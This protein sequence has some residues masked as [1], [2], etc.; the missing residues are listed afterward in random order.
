METSVVDE[1]TEVTL[2]GPKEEPNSEHPTESTTFVVE[3]AGDGSNRERDKTMSPISFEKT[4][5]RQVQAALRRLHQNL[6]HPS[7]E[8]LVRHLRLAG[9]GA[10]VVKAAKGMSCQVCARH[11]RAGS[12]RPSSE[13]VWL[14]FN[15]VVGVDVFTIHTPDD[16]KYDLLSVIDYGTSYHV[17][18]LLP[19]HNAEEIE[20]TFNSLWSNTFGPPGTI[21]LDQ[22]PG[23]QT[24][25][26]RYSSWYG[27]KIRSSAGQGH[28]QQGRVER[29]GRHWKEILNRVMDDLSVLQKDELELAVIATNSAKNELTKIHGFSPAQMVFGRNPKTL[30]ELP[31]IGREDEVTITSPDLRRQRETAIRAGAKAAFFRAQAD[32]K[33]RRAL[34]QRSRVSQDEVAVGDMVC[35]LRKPKDRKEYVWKG[36]G[37]VIGQEG[38]NFWVSQGG[39]CHLCAVEHLRRASPEELGDAFAL[40]VTRDDLERLLEADFDDPETYEPDDGEM[41]NADEAFEDDNNDDE[42]ME[43]IPEMPSGDAEGDH[44]PEGDETRGDKRLTADEGNPVLLKRIRKKGPG[45][46]GPSSPAVA[47]S[48][49]AKRASTARG[50]EKALEKELPWS[51]IPPEM[52]QAFR[53]AEVK[54]WREHIDHGALEALSLAE[55]QEV[56]DRVD[57][58][59]IL[60]SRF[61]YKDKHYAKRRADPSTP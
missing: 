5:P 6:G 24:A 27:S 12:A 41:E 45:D 7:R 51:A 30:E 3:A 21:A 23:L 43:E 1:I 22:E 37:V 36:P 19:G 32:G 25:F 4:V 48:Y 53:D 42:P 29:H 11:K 16:Q 28:W 40:R 52:V 13:P 44:N 55:S 20:R 54:Q 2:G 31:D 57:P 8:D 59:R 15:Q 39:R 46:P 26:G 60:G 47:T 9:A 34:L 61:A 17:A 49:M 50:R 35:F 38:G 58:R 18:G 14:D 33:L 10:E 56:R